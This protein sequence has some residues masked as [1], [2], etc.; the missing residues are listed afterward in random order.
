MVVVDGFLTIPTGF[1]M[2]MGFSQ[3]L[4]KFS[5]VQCRLDSFMLT[6]QFSSIKSEFFYI[7][8]NTSAWYFNACVCYVAFLR[9]ACVRGNSWEL[10][11]THR[12]LW[13]LMRTYANLWELMGTYGNLWELM[14]TY[15]NL[16]E[17]MG[18]YGSL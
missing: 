14:G 13:E 6:K 8:T 9:H 3:I 17:L 1:P 7:S 15:G 10:M 2:T 5:I 4:R 11:G 18:T 16:W 12:N